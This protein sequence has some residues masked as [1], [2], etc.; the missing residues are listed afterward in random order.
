VSLPPSSVGP[1]T[2]EQ[3]VRDLE[4]WRAKGV[5]HL[6]GLSLPGLRQAALAA[7]LADSGAEASEPFVLTDLVRRAVSTIA[8]SITGRCSIVLLGLDPDTFDLAPNLL[9]EE[10]AEIYGVSW[11]RFRREPQKAVLTAVAERVL[12][13]CQAY[14]ARVARL[15]LEQRHPADTRL[16]VQWLERF[17]FYF[18][19]WTSVYALGADLTA[20]RET[21]IETKRPWDAPGVGAELAYTQE[22]QAA[23]YGAFALFH[24]ACVLVAE[25]AFLARYG[26]LW[27][28]SSPQAEVETR[29]A[30]HAVTLTSPMNERDRSFLRTAHHQAGGEMHEFLEQLTIDRI[31]TVTLEEW[32]EWLLG[33]Q[34]QW[35]PPLHNPAIEYFPSARFHIGID[36]DCPVHEVVELAGR[37]CATI[38]QEWIKVADWYNRDF[39]TPRKY[40]SGGPSLNAEDANRHQDGASNE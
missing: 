4:S 35:S 7:G 23:G 34:C 1:P 3:L 10:A 26:G 2:V 6:R 11:E 22:N 36:A 38:E 16:A 39:P 27:L 25:Q 40:S 24:F 20:C 14:R 13:Q 18:G 17:E 19:I 8:G 12:E 5:T 28:L 30:L 32:N 31:G 29:D 9:R 33:C 15:A 21:L 37:F